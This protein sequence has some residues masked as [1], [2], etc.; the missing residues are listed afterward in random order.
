LGDLFEERIIHIERHDLGQ[1]RIA[2]QRIAAEQ[3]SDRLHDGDVLG[4]GFREDL[5]ESFVVFRSEK[6]K[7]R[8][9]R[10]G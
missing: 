6:G 2:R 3:P 8:G 5:L 9:E 4:I 10:A 1:R 7:G